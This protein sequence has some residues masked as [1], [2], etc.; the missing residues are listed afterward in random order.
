VSLE[1]EG[2]VWQA[3]GGSSHGIQACAWEALEAPQMCHTQ[4]VFWRGFLSCAWDRSAGRQKRWTTHYFVHMPRMMIADWW[5]L[6]RPVP[7]GGLLFG[8]S[9]GFSFSKGM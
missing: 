5:A 1:H 3:A 2:S 8:C 4:L 7:R 9:A 6:R